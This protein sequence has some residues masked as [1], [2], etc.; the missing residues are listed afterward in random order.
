[1]I[2]LIEDARHCYEEIV[3]RTK[4]YNGKVVIFV[5]FDIDSLCSLRILVALLRSDNLKYEIIPVMNYGQLD[6]K[7]DEFK[8]SFDSI[9][10]DSNKET[11]AFVMINCGGTRDISKS[12]FCESGYDIMCLLIDV[13]RPTHHNNINENKNII[14]INDNNYDFENCPKDEDLLELENEIEDEDEDDFFEEN[15][16]EE[17]EIENDENDLEESLKNENEI[18]E[19]KEKSE[20]EEL[21]EENENSSTHLKKEDEDNIVIDINEHNQETTNE[22]RKKLRRLK[23]IGE[24]LPTINEENEDETDRILKPIN[25][26]KKKKSAVIDERQLK[27]KIRYKK[28]MKV[29]NYYSGNYFGF[30]A[31]FVLYKMAEQLH[32]EEISTLWYLIISMTDHYIQSHIGNELYDELYKE[33]HKEVLRLNQSKRDLSLNS[34]RNTLTKEEEL[35]ANNSKYDFLNVKVKTSNKEAKSISLESDYRLILYRHWNLFDS[36]IY[37]SYIMGNYITWKEAGKEEVKKLITYIGIPLEEAKQKYSSMRNEYKT[38]FNNK[39]VNICKSFNI[40]EILFHSFL[41]QYNQKTQLS[42]SDFV[43]CTSSILD[44]PF[45][46]N[47]IDSGEGADNTY[48]YL[49]VEEETETGEEKDINETDSYLNYTKEERSMR[50]NHK[51]ENFWTAYDFLSFKNPSLLKLSIDLAIKFQIATVNKGTPIIDKRAI[52]VTK[53]FRYHVINNDTDDEIKYFHYPL[54]LEKLALFILETH[55]A[56]HKN[57]PN[58]IKKP[59]VLA[60]YIAASKSYLVAGVMGNSKYSDKE[61]NQFP[62]RFRLSANKVNARL[63]LN[64]FNDCIVELAKEDFLSFFDELSLV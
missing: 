43:Y 19:C 48:N 47:K 17:E 50:M 7:L 29:Q 10:S 2:I 60:I 4:K 64:S 53:N 61:K 57:D 27:R 34:R 30:P 39:L 8:K 51:Y 32:R 45:N 41:Y 24:N 16:E 1:M 21:E 36:F 55:N 26:P 56:I 6:A 13:H 42:A 9:G 35:A 63:M 38:L 59:F 11:K 23:K 31:S 28:R 54:S 20:N 18:S 5:G 3:K 12:W 49:E 46:L 52:S 25:D 37:S 14:I 40:D 22:E 58:F 33:C 44:Y 62:I 15:E